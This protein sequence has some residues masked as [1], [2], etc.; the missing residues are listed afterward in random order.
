M[1]TYKY[2][3]KYIELQESVQGQDIE[4]QIRIIGSEAADASIRKVQEHFENNEIITDVMLYTYK[5][6]TYQFI[7]RQDYYTDF[8]LAL[9]K[10]KLLVSVEWKATL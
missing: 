5:N 7:V 8:I 10:Y 4:F 6:H 1:L 3:N 9:M 2:D